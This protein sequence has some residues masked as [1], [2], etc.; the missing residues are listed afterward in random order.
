MEGEIITLQEI[1]TFEQTGITE[2]RKVMGKFAATGVRPKFVEK[3]K[4]LGIELS[5]EIFDPLNV[6]EV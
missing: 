2:E 6:Y 5:P 3:F 1:F 4:S